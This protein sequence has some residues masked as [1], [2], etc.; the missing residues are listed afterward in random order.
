MITG[1]LTYSTSMNHFPGGYDKTNSLSR[2]GYWLRWTALL[3]GITGALLF[4]Y[5]HLS[6]PG[7]NLHGWNLV[8]WLGAL[9]RV[10][11]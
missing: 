5:R 10:E 3:G 8:G 7:G 9:P 11:L 6:K 1:S 4:V 2:L